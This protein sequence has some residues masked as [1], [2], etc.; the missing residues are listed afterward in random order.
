MDKR[1][2][3]P[4]DLRVK[5]DCPWKAMNAEPGRANPKRAL[6]KPFPTGTAGGGAQWDA[7]PPERMKPVVSV[8]IGKDFFL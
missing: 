6:P 5:S 7:G 3:L 1:V 8:I 2:I 4:Q